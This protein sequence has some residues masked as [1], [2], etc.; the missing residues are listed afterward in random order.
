[1][2]KF[3]VIILG[4]SILSSLRLHLVSLLLPHGQL[5]DLEVYKMV[6]PRWNYKLFNL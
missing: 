6:G 5:H 1:M 2:T 4:K 3:R